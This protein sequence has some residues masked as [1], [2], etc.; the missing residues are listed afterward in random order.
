VLAGV[1][2]SWT[3]PSRDP[4]GRIRDDAY[5][6][7]VERFSN[8]SPHPLPASDA[9][10][11]AA[12]TYSP[13]I[14]DV[15][16]DFAEELLEREGLGRGERTD[17]LALSLSGTDLIGHLYGPFSQESRDA[18]ARLD[19]RLGD[20]LAKLE[21]GVGKG[22]ILVVLTADHGVLPIPE[23]ESSQSE[24][25][26]RCEVAGGRVDEAA[27][28]RGLEAELDRA[29]GVATDAGRWMLWNSLGLRLRTG[30]A[31][32]AG[33]NSGA[34]LGRA[35]QWLTAQPGIDRVWSA[36]EIQLG[37]GEEPFATLYRN[38]F[39]SGRDPDLA[40]QPAFGCLVTRWPAGTSHGSPHP[41]DRRVPLV[42]W[43]AGVEPG[44]D[45]GPAATV[46]IA[47]TLADVLGLGPPSDLDGRVLKLAK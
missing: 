35:A 20:F 15:V 7:E 11:I 42:F 13:F 33:A 40:L 46:D 12:L 30:R 9:E 31:E 29:F 34:V 27:L 32:A 43:G 17:L 21:S 18:L 22:R 45:D 47:P 38:S 44:V 4:L 1:P 25:A 24:A 41:Y 10:N 26:E 23:W 39:A 28:V 6:H 3:H 2:V 5:P 16:L 8:V 14:D 36:E 37:Q 19:R